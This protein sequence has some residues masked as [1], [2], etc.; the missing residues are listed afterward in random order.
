[1]KNTHIYIGLVSILIIIYFKYIWSPLFN[2]HDKEGMG[3]QMGNQGT[4]TYNSLFSTNPNIQGDWNLI[5]VDGGAT[6]RTTTKIRVGWYDNSSRPAWGISSL[7][8]GSPVYIGTYAVRGLYMPN[9]NTM[10]VGNCQNDSEKYIGVISKKY[11]FHVSKIDAVPPPPPPSVP[12]PPPP[13]VPPPPPPPPPSVP[14]CTYGGEWKNSSPECPACYNIDSPETKTQIQAA[15]NS[16]CDGPTTTSRTINCKDSVPVCD[17]C[18][19]NDWTAWSE[20]SKPCNGGTRTRTRTLKN[21]KGTCNELSQTENCNVQACNPC[22]YGEIESSSACSVECGGG[23]Q[24][25]V[26]KLVN[27]HGNDSCPQK[28]ESK[29][30][31]IDPCADIM[32]VITPT[33]DEYWSLYL[34]NKY[35]SASFFTINVDNSPSIGLKSYTKNKC[36]SLEECRIKYKEDNKNMLAAANYDGR[37]LLD[38]SVCPNCE[39]TYV[40][41]DG[42]TETYSDYRGTIDWFGNGIRQWATDE[43]RKTQH[44][45]ECKYRATLNAPKNSYKLNAQNAE[46]YRDV[47]IV[48]KFQLSIDLQGIQLPYTVYYYFN[49]SN[50]GVCSITNNGAAITTL[51]INNNPNDFGKTLNAI[52]INGNGVPSV[53]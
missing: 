12:P 18:K 20:C 10:I 16:P 45:K 39:Y 24:S 32:N 49:S 14:K 44:D 1:M 25:T 50:K 7:N 42:Y 40:C 2:Y 27:K 8:D 29:P 17:Y 33:Y 3:G 23:T 11:T 46:K 48:S 37:K 28:I 22:E 9:A 15:N 35:N 6:N 4:A 38:D 34:D 31:N 41:N 47:L 43:E 36:L 53:F 21:G 5:S 30:C 13:S 19:Y 51:Q 26:Y 52:Y